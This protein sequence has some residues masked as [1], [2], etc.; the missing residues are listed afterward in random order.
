MKKIIISL[1]MLVA[2]L[3]PPALTSCGKDGG[4][5]PEPDNGDSKQLSGS[6]RSVM[7][8]DASAEYLLTGPLIVEEGAELHIP[9]GT[10]IKAR[11][12][13]GSY[14]LVQ[15][16]G[17]INVNGTAERPV[18]MTADAEDA[19]PGHW[20]GLIINGRAPLSGGE[21]GRTE[22]NNACTYGGTDAADNSGTLTWLILAFTGARSSA[23]VE[24]NGLTLNGVGNATR[25]ENICI[26]HSADDGIEFFGGTVNVRNLLVVN[27]DDDMFDFTQGYS[28]TLENAFGIWEEDYV[29][30]E[31]DPRGVEADGNLDGNNPGQHGQSDFTIRN[32]TIDLR[33]AAAT[34][35][36]Y[37]MHDVLKIRRGARVTVQNALVK[38]CGQA[39]DLV[40]MTDGKGAGNATT[41]ISITNALTAP[42]SGVE[43]NGTAGNI[44][45]I[46][47]NTGCPSGIFAWTGY[48]LDAGN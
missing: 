15:Q 9:A 3:A 10:L 26:R 2:I 39:K 28:G 13:F 25:I 38:G 36:G 45:V 27:P 30:S 41:A 4:N 43:K 18:T 29:S 31:E 44:T 32:M 11:K 8:L 42:L 24:H 34:T 35:E 48:N 22:I 20:G 33:T 47:G 16:G 46:P 23:D 21:T 5:E 1:W 7:T 14:I 6:V 40:D 37:Y 12:G 17:K 19:S